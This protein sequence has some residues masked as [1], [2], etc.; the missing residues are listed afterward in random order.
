LS[1]TTVALVEQ[2]AQEEVPGGHKAFGEILVTT[3]TK[4]F[5]KIRWYT[6]ET[7]GQEPLDLPPSELQTTG[8]WLSLSQ[9]AVDD[10][11]ERGLWRNAP[12]DYGPHWNRIRGQ[13]R[14]RDEY[15]C[16]VCGA[17]EQGRVH[18]V[19]H[20]IPFRAFATVEQ[21]N[22]LSNLV[23][24]C[25]ACH[26]RVEAAVRMR[27][28]LAGLSYTLGNL[29]PLF[30]MCDSRDLGVHSD[31]Q[32][33]L[34]EGL[35]AVVLYDRVPAGIGLAESLYQQHAELLRQ[36]QRLVAECAC[37]DGCPSCVGPGGEAGSGGKREA[38]AI[39]EIMVPK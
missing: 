30:V 21:A 16:Q 2:S 10:L 18:D 24:L 33:P 14:A 23:T 27:S 36:A 32:S 28:G 17:P 20:K 29:A 35:P 3:I 12:N 5:R 26:H 31:P 39:L 4:G 13:V 15:R 37:T 7:L 34:A 6:G 9:A 25:P 38:L 22:Q 8:Y 19:H 11:S 1:E